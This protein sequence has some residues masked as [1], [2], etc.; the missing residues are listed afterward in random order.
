ML[1]ALEILERFVE[2]LGIGLNVREYLVVF[3]INFKESTKVEN[4]VRPPKT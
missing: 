2:V 1:I 4:D 3:I